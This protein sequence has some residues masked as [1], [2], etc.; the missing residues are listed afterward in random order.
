MLQR[1]FKRFVTYKRDFEE[2]LL[3][4]LQGLV[5]EQLRFEAYNG[6]APSAD[7]YVTVSIG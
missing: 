1:K 7:G 2:L 4:T 5:R 3:S 6:T